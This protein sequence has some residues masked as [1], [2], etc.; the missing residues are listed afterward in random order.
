MSHF[1]FCVYFFVK[2]CVCN[3]CVTLSNMREKSCVL[4]KVPLNHVFGKCLSQHG[5]HQLLCF[6]FSGDAVTTGHIC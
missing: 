1:V 5:W 4:S 6:W 3:L 2:V